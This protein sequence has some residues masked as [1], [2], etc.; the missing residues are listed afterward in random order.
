MYPGEELNLHI[1]EPRYKQLIQFCIDSKKPFGIPPV[2][3]NHINE[4]GTLVEIVEVSKMY[5]S[6]E[7]D[8]KTKA[9]KVFR[10]LEIVK[11]I[12]D[13]LYSGAM[14]SY[15]NNTIGGERKRMH[16]I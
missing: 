11:E 12:P 16:K 14:V 6:G 15:P 1:F 7:M 8:I 13:K 2:I 5:D 4:K 3:D 10:I 9:R